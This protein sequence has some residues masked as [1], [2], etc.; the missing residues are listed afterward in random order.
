M[1]LDRMVACKRAYPSGNATLANSSNMR[2]TGNCRPENAVM[3][4]DRIDNDIVPAKNAGM[5]TIWIRQGFGGMAENLTA[6]ETP[7]YCVR[8]LQELVELLK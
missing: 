1:F 4:G 3:I 6:E 2:R 8:N 7:D 5:M